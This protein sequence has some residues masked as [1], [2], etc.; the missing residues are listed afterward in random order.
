MSGWIFISHSSLDG[1]VAGRVAEF[2]EDHGHPSWIAPRNIIPGQD[3]PGAIA[4]AVDLCSLFAV[5][6]SRNSCRSYQ[7]RTEIERAVSA[8]KTIIPL[9]L[10][11]TGLSGWMDYFISSRHW[12]AL[13]ENDP[14]G[15]LSGVLPALEGSGQAHFSRDITVLDPFIREE[16]D[17]LGA[18]L[19]LLEKDGPSKPVPGSMR[20]VTILCLRIL[21][22]REYP[23]EKREALVRNACAGITERVLKAYGGVPE[24]VGRDSLAGLFGS[25]HSREDDPRRAVSC[26]IRLQKAMGLLNDSPDLKG[27]R[28]VW[29]MGVTSGM[30][31]MGENTSDFPLFSEEAVQTAMEL[32][33]REGPFRVTDDVK[34]LC[35]GCFDWCSVMGGWSVAEHRD[36]TGEDIQSFQPAFFGRKQELSLLRDHFI[37]GQLRIAEVS[38]ESGMGKTRLALALEECTS[39]AFGIRVFKG[40]CHSFSKTPL[41]LWRSLLGGLMGISPD[42]IP[43]AKVLI[44]AGEGI[45]DLTP[46]DKA[47]LGRIFGVVISGG[48]PTPGDPDLEAAIFIADA[49]QSAAAPSSPLV[50]L[51]DVQWIDS[52]SLEVL[53]K[54]RNLMEWERHPGILLLRRSDPGE[55]VA[56]GLLHGS[57]AVSLRG[58]TEEEVVEFTSGVIQTRTG[59]VSPVV[60]RETGRLLWEV[61]RGNPLL[62]MN[63]VDQ[64][65]ESGSL[66]GETGKWRLTS[67]PDSIAAGDASSILFGRMGLFSKR[68]ERIL[69]AAAVAGSVFS[70]EMVIYLCERTGESPYGVGRELHGLLSTGLLQCVT[71]GEY[72]FTSEII[73]ETVLSSIL[74]VNRKLF[75]LL[76]GEFTE[77]RVT[78][79]EGADPS[80]VFAHFFHAGDTSRAFFWGRTSLERMLEG[81]QYESAMRTASSVMEVTGWKDF[82]EDPEDYSAFLLLYG[83]ACREAG[84]WREAYDIYGKACDFA[85]SNGLAGL[86]FQARACRAQQ[87]VSMGENSRAVKECLEILES[88]G[89]QHFPEV[90]MRVNRNVGVAH[91]R[92]GKS[93]EAETCF[94]K[95]LAV[96][97]A[98]GNSLAEA[99][100]LGNIA[101]VRASQGKVDEAIELTE[102]KLAAVREAGSL[103]EE[104]I[105]ESNLGAC[106]AMKGDFTG[107]AAHFRRQLELDERTGR[108]QGILAALSNLANLAEREP[109]TGDRLSLYI[110]AEKLAR[111]MGDLGTLTH[112]L[113]NKAPVLHEKGDIAGAI[114][115]AKEA[116]LL[117]EATGDHSLAARNRDNLE[118]L[119]G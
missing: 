95:N 48:H 105:A 39:G 88:P 53:R 117:A 67:L 82:S 92:T 40:N 43:D 107:A 93:C 111:R 63:L 32:A 50:I 118:K 68:R 34:D 76:A 94:R 54:L 110:Q 52:S 28:V 4:S 16:I 14:I 35:S 113:G 58:L 104:A 36:E 83:E 65:L 23:G 2:F 109:G 72:R 79:G 62:L 116:I 71:Q 10:Q 6:V 75:H 70:A 51:D 26:A 30:M 22:V 19:K 106:R 61:S 18:H 97:E 13:D 99:V 102:R 91:W 64:T 25:R 47:I 87:L 27:L 59:A 85:S 21:G 80:L 90:L 5:V 55:E 60:F 45:R 115:A 112:V 73:R 38:G 108:R 33:S 98:M 89:I 56:S 37:P 66:S 15:S 119:L 42:V 29:G 46:A 1:A 3:W 103:K 77:E 78:S 41:Y 31:K 9:M 96:A 101:M 74:P 7:V 49:L 44:R 17:S 84:R 86:L 11:T 81:C 20:P 57:L 69:H 12:H 114:A 24:P 100:A 8:G